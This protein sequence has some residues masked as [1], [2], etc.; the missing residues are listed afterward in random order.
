MPNIVVLEFQRSPAMLLDC[1]VNGDA[2]EPH[3]SAM[4]AVG[5]PC[6][7]AEGVKLLAKPEEVT[8]RMK[9]FG[10]SVE[11]LMSELPK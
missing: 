8:M 5:R 3:R 4:L 1:I 2:L 6:V 11:L 10:I 9:L 7:F